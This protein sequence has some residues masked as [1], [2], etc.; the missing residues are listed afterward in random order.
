MQTHGLVGKGRVDMLDFGG[1]NLRVEVFFEVPFCFCGV[2][3][4]Q[5]HQRT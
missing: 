4:L 1:W 5:M 2:D 3:F